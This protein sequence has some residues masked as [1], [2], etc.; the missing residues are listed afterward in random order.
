M[1]AITIFIR[2]TPCWCGIPR[3]RDVAVALPDGVQGKSSS[4]PVWPEA[5]NLLK[6][7]E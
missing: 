3:L 2:F 7:K 5:I 4:M 1:I 6:I